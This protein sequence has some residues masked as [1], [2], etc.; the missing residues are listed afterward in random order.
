MRDFKSLMLLDRFERLFER[1]GV[2]YKVMRRILEVKLMM[3]GRRVPTLVG[4]SSNKPENP[5]RNNF[6]RSLWLYVVLSIILVPFVVMGQNYMFQMS[7]IFGILIFMI[8]TALISDFS[9]V[10]LDI[11]D[12]NILYSKPVN[13]LTINMAKAIHIGIYLFFITGSLTIAP[14]VAGLV[15]HGILFLL[16]FLITIVLMDLFIVVLTAVLYWFVLRFFDGEKLKDIINYVQIGLTIGMTIGY[17]VVSRMFSVTN[18]KI[19]FKPEWWQFMI[20]PAWFAAPFEWLFN[21][22]SQPSIILFSILALVVPVLA[23]R[24]YMAMMPSFEHHLQKLSQISSVREPSRFSIAAWMGGI[25]CTTREESLFYRFASNMMKNE[26]DFKLKVYPSLGLAF[27]FPFI[28]MFNGLHNGGWQNMMSGSSYLFIYFCGMMIPTIVMMLK[29][30]GNHKGAWIYNTIPLQ[31]QSSIFKGTLKASIMRLMVPIYLIESIVFI[32]LFGV[33]IIPDLF[34]VWVTMMLYTVVSYKMMRKALPFSEPFQTAQ[35]NQFGVTLLLMFI[36]AA[37]AG[38]HLVC[39]Q[40]TYGVL[41]LLIVMI[42]AN[43]VTWKLAFRSPHPKS[44]KA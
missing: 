5:D 13:G 22:N 39:A 38:I 30:S 21:G 36:L 40:F 33:R 19:E 16:L 24:L 14:L 34:V 32:I 35:H 42:V 25:F 23:V 7:L 2:D 17:Q 10:L 26:R 41:V 18:F 28:F 29:F 37:F 44:F 6:I 15:R 8:T 11:R 31:D 20:F 3:D 12:R 9:S 43:V 4:K 27:I 1:G